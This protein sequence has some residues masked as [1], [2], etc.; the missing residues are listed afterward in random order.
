MFIDIEWLPVEDVFELELQPNLDQSRIFTN[1]VGYSRLDSTKELSWS[2]WHW[3]TQTWSPSWSAAAQPHGARWCCWGR[4]RVTQRD[5]QECRVQ[6]CFLQ[7]KKSAFTNSVWCYTDPPGLVTS[8]IC[9]PPGPGLRWRQQSHW[10][11]KQRDFVRYPNLLNGRS[12][13]HSNQIQ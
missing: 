9:S 1:S 13:E 4:W 8:A 6:S 11:T 12:W 7:I 2:P 5:W 3:T 10:S